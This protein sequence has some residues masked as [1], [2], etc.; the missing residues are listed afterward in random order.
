MHVRTLKV[1]VE[2]DPS[3]VLFQGFRKSEGFYEKFSA[4][5]LDGILKR[6]PSITVVEFDAYSSVMRNG[7]MM[8]GLGEAVSKY[9]K[10][11]AWGPERGW[12]HEGDQVWLDALLMHG[13]FRKWSKNI[14]VLAH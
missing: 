3:D 6:V 2:C 10:V 12:D 13:G 1:F 8:S 7:D 9:K 11:V 4:D 14:A 5:L